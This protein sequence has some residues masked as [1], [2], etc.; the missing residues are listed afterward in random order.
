MGKL[1]AFSARKQ[2]YNTLDGQIYTGDWVYLGNT[3]RV[4]KVLQ[5]DSN[6]STAGNMLYTLIEPITNLV[7]DAERTRIRKITN[8]VKI[9]ELNTL[10]PNI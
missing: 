10:Y 1:R 3:I 9:N 7:M 8:I 4:F 6:Y 2:N 5:A